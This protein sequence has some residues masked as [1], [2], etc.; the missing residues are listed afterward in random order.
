M[1]RSFIRFAAILAAA[2]TAQ[3]QNSNWCADGCA[4]M[5]YEFSSS[6][7]AGETTGQ[8]APSAGC[9][10]N[11][12]CATSGTQGGCGLLGG[13]GLSQLFSSS[14]EDGAFDFGGWLQ[15]G[16]HSRDGLFRFNTHPH[17]LNIHQAWL[18]AEKVADGSDG[19]DW[20]FRVDA[21][22][23]VDGADT[24]AFGNSPGRWDFDN[25]FDHG[26]FAFALPQAYVEVAS[27][28]WSIKAGHFFTLVG[29]EV[30]TAP[31]NFFY[32]HAFTMY[33]SEPFTHTGAVAT[34]NASDSLTVYGGWTTGWDTGFDTF[35][36]GSSFLG[37]AAFNINESITL[38]Y[39]TTIGN[40]G[41]RG[42][43]YGHSIVL[44]MELSDKW[45]YVI[46]SDYLDTDSALNPLGL[47]DDEQIGINQYMFYELSDDVSIGG[48]Y[49]WW[50]VGGLSVNDV[51]LGLNINVLD[52]L[53][54]RPE[55]RHDWAPGLNYAES[56]F[57]VDAIL[58]F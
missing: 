57:G 50:N 51:T 41:A 15:S 19:F 9:P 8:C 42:D 17:R 1:Y 22:Y 44:D 21:M 58:T 34:Y 14:K 37:G 35:D 28:N 56:F 32:S 48:R 29:Y 36:N 24:Q 11:T 12:N 53:K 18:Y 33:N 27:G 20:G 4:P 40:F 47:P 10:P 39:I 54:I 25:G 5:T 38:T 46:Q 3:A 6:Q 30:V 52:D 7:F 26:Q 23:G 31:D 43:G 45:N 16:Y 49:E 13:T 55:V 2:T